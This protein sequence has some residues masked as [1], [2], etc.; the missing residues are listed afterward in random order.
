MR[1][2]VICAAYKYTF[3]HSCI[4]HFITYY[5]LVPENGVL[6]SGLYKG[7]CQTCNKEV[8][9]W[10]VPSPVSEITF[11]VNGTQYMVANPDPEMSLNEWIR[12]QPGLQGID[13][14]I[15]LR[16]CEA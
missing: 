8:T 6:S 15:E 12:N 10:S 3:I 7:E 16:D 5:R 4:S 11:T 14:L 9:F 13:L 1:H 2:D